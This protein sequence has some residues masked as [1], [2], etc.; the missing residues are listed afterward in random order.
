MY[1]CFCILCSVFCV[2]YSVFCSV[3]FMYMSFRAHP[4]SNGPP[5]FSSKIVVGGGGGGPC[6][7]YGVSAVLGGPRNWVFP[8]QNHHVPRH[9]NNRYINSYKN[10]VGPFSR[11][12]CQPKPLLYGDPVRLLTPSTLVSF[13]VSF[14]AVTVP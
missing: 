3:S 5:S 12:R 7:V 6:K 1:I 9:I 14:S 8:H 11:A 4:P 2:L 10:S 13:S